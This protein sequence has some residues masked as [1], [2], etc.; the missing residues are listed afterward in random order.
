MSLQAGTETGSQAWR[1]TIRIAMM[2]L[3]RDVEQRSGSG[4]FFFKHG[5]SSPLPATSVFSP[6]SDL[7]SQITKAVQL[8]YCYPFTKS[9][10]I[11][12]AE[13]GITKIR[14]TQGTLKILNSDV[15][16]VFYRAFSHWCNL[17]DR[18]PEKCM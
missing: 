9:F 15:C 7:P 14:V 2:T 6:N 11:L 1:E 18:L 3:R 4:D 8:K 17:D 12:Y 10:K 16:H 13:R 5:G